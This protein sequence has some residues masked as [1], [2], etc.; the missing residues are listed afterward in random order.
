MLKWTLCTKV[1]GINK[2]FD[3]SCYLLK[4]FGQSWPVLGVG[5]SGQNV[6]ID[7]PVTGGCG[8]PQLPLQV[9]CCRCPP[10]SQKSL[11]ILLEQKPQ[12]IREVYVSNH[13]ESLNTTYNSANL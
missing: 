12:Q 5:S 10:W 4:H 13:C 1:T 9:T 6:S 11:L 3:K 2:Y 8:V 7:L